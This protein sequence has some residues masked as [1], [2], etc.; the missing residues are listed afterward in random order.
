M[1]D[2][3][4]KLNQAINKN[5]FPAYLMGEKWYRFNDKWVESPT[6]IT[7][8]FISGFNEYVI[9]ENENKEKLEKELFNAFVLILKNPVGTW[10]T[11]SILYSY[12]FGY[13][14]NTLLFIIDINSLVP[15]I[16]K[17]LME[18]KE[19]LKVNK[20]WVGW[21]FQNGLWDDVTYM[22][23]RINETIKKNNFKT[24]VT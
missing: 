19:S 9:Q 15:I 13:K 16:N 11:I 14:E 22:V 8:V 18:F 4:N 7:K 2:A 1:N 12:L 3:L 21:R 6:D 5:E 23:N 24:I 20:D 10:W 17:S